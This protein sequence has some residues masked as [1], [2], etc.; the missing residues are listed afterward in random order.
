V[1]E[2]A[3]QS[4]RRILDHDGRDGLSADLRLS[5]PQPATTAI[6]VRPTE[7]LMKAL[8][9]LAFAAL[10]ATAASADAQPAAPPAA[11]PAAAA[12]PDPAAFLAQNAKA[13][14]VKTLPSGLQYKITQSGSAGPS[15]KPGDII[16]VHYEGKLTSGQVFDSTFER[17]HPAIMPLDE[18]IP[19]W[20]EAI[21]MM[22][23]GDEWTLYVPPSLGYGAQ[24]AGPIPA[25]SVLV[26]RI[27]LLGMLS[28]D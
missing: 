3:G 21:P 11:P 23:V 8:I 16:K 5:F 9:P 22:H 27:K 28:A 20:M 25:N 2:L 17:G 19:A 7:F 26:F 12:A 4:W 1:E 18:L 24:G 15:P 10:L 6:C 14:G 13:P